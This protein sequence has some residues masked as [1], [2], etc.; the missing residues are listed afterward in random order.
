MEWCISFIWSN[1]VGKYKH[2]STV[3]Y[4]PTDWS[5]SPI[6]LFVRNRTDKAEKKDTNKNRNMSKRTTP[7]EKQTDI[8]YVILGRF[9]NHFLH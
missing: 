1:Y 7:V 9:I 3:N 4:I 6:N 8:Y 5:Y 2:S